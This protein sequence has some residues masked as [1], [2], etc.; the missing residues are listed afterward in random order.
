M[1]DLFTE[2]TIVVVDDLLFMG[3]GGHLLILGILNFLPL[4]VEHPLFKTSG[5][6]LFIFSKVT[7]STSP[8]ASLVV[9]I[10]IFFFFFIKR[11]G[12]GGMLVGFFGDLLLQLLVDIVLLLRILLALGAMFG[13][14]LVVKIYELEN[15]VE[16]VFMVKR[17]NRMKV[18]QRG[19]C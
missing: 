14:P 7:F 13:K 12:D 10:F 8:S 4:G 2:E 19:L 1:G 3:A 5:L 11:V 9:L 17:W 16:I 18:P 15:E 6:V